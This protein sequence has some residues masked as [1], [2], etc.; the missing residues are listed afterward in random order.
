MFQVTASGRLSEY[1]PTDNRASEDFVATALL[2]QKTMY[3]GKLMDVKLVVW[4]PKYK[5]E[6]AKKMAASNAFVIVQSD[7]FIRQAS[8]ADNDRGVYWHIQMSS[9]H[10]F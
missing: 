8:K 6:I 3:D 2:S 4:I 7:A 1:T 9:V 5:S 10:Y